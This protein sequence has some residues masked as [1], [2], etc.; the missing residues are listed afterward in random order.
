MKPEVEPSH[1]Y[2][3]SYDT[4]ERFISYWHQI[5]EIIPLSPKNVLEIG[6]GNGF[7]ASYLKKL[8]IN[9]TTLDIDIRLDADIIASVLDIPFKKDCFEVVSCF[10]VLEHLPFESLYSALNEIY[11]VSS[12][13]LIISLP[14]VSLHYPVDIFIPKYGF[15]KKIIP[16]YRLK[17]LK[18]EY[19]GHH[20]WEIG[21]ADYPLSRIISAIK[22]ANF[23]IEKTYRIF[24]YPYHRFFILSKL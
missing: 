18:H 24:E 12:R 17:K 13:Y 16:L 6:V 15:I 11:R 7:L 2:G 1:Y 19:T 8:D 23:H 20:Y 22:K 14:D 21:K 4:K 10:E 9:I 3:L 5:S